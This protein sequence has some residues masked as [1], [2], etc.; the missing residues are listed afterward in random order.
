MADD[1]NPLVVIRT[2]ARYHRVE[3]APSCM[4]GICHRGSLFGGELMSSLGQQTS[5]AI[6]L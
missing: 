4:Q 6:G 1:N 3:K 2:P 5:D